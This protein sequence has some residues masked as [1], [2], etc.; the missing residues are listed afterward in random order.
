MIRGYFDGPPGRLRPFVTVRL[1]IPAQSIAG[2]VRFLID[3]GAD[4]TVLAPREADLLGIN[5]QHLPAGPLSAGV[6][7]HTPTATVAAALTLDT[8]T[9]TTT[10]RLL[11][12]TSLRQRQALSVIPSLLGRD[13]LEHFAL[14]VEERTD[15]VLL[16]EP[17]EAD[18]LPLPR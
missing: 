2:R 5:P 18:A 12:P 17:D 10:L 15:R 1:A 16:L 3:T 11:A 13:V 14:F 7:G 4:F 6:G 8:L 9:F